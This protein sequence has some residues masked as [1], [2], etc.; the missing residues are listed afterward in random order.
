MP[1]KTFPTEPVAFSGIGAFVG[2]DYSALFYLHKVLVL[3]VTLINVSHLMPFQPRKKQK[4][5]VS[6]P[7]FLRWSSF[8]QVSLLALFKLRLQ[9]LCPLQARLPL[10]ARLQ[11]V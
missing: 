6:L 8:R 11:A 10:L 4:A 5:R 7:R 1:F 2:Y 3:S 9:A